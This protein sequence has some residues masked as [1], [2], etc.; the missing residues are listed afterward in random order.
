MSYDLAMSELFPIELGQAPR[1]VQNSYL[2]TVAPRLRDRPEQSD[3]PTVK[4]LKGWKLWRYRVGSYRL[5]YAVDAQKKI[6][7]LMMVGPRDSIYDRLGHISEKGPAARIIVRP[8]L[9]IY[10][11]HKPTPEEIGQALMAAESERT[12]NGPV[13]EPDTPLPRRI[14]KA[15]L[16][17]CSVPDEYMA[18]LL[19]VETEGDLLSCGAPDKFI[20]RVLIALYPPPLEVVAQKAKRSVHSD[21]ELDKAARGEKSLED[22][23]LALDEDQQPFVSR[24]EKERPKGP[25]MVKGGPGSGKS[26]VALYCIKG[27][28]DAA[29][30]PKLFKDKPLRILFTTFTKSLILASSHLLDTFGLERGKHY[31][32]VR[33]VDKLATEFL[34]A[35]LENVTAID[36][37]R[38]QNERNIRNKVINGALRACQASIPAF[39]FSSGETDFLMDEIDWVIIGDGI[40]NLEDYK[41]ADRQGRGRGLSPKQREHVWRYHLELRRELKDARRCLLS[42]RLAEACQNAEPRYDYVFID[43]AQ[44][45]KPVAIRFCLKLAADP[46]HVFLTADPNQTIYGASM[47]WKRVSE[48]LN[49]RGRTKVFRRNYRTTMETWGGIREIVDSL[50]DADQETID[51]EPVYSGEYPSLYRY[52]NPVDEVVALGRWLTEA[53]LQERVSAS[54]AAVLCP[55]NKICQRIADDLDQSLNPKAFSTGTLDLRHPGV[56]VMTMHAVKGLQFPVVAVTGLEAGLMPWRARGGMD[57]AENEVKLRRLF[58]VACSRAMR[59]LL[60]MGSSEK[61]SPFLSTLSEDAWEIL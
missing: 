10:K 34:P 52:K 4:K 36:S 19:S 30:Q 15:F 16:G 32:E 58:F 61:P 5:I 42:D 40:T 2:K 41:E 53:I 38:S 54:C 9:D 29:N 26:T 46:A 37:P 39:S 3:P 55:T 49:F 45:L 50:S 11:E 48:D 28:A 20:E 33:N 22:F 24:F 56:K 51:E 21:E 35:A 60:V 25:W 43:E 31:I 6:V 47:P 8:E 57:P 14:D 7:T 27:L 59:R 12:P 23:L 17:S 18:G 1:K 13:G 44:D